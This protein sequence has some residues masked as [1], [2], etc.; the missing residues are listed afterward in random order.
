MNKYLLLPLFSVYIV[1]F[2]NP[3]KKDIN[4]SPYQPPGW[5]FG[6]VWPILLLLIG[7]SWTLRSSLSN[8]YFIQTLLLSSWVVFY[9]KNKLYGLVNILI[10]LCLTLF[11][12]GY[13]YKKMSSL[14]LVPL[15]A[16]LSFASFLSYDTLYNHNN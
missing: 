12:I 8:Y 9:N 10:T 5:I 14:L 3:M 6:L 2:F 16:W 7:Y 4:P 11:M 15:A 13:K 1:T